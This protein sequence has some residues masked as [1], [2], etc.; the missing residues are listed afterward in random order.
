ML[1]VLVPHLPE[2]DIFPR[3]EM[4]IGAWRDRII[5]FTGIY[6]PTRPLI[7]A[8]LDCGAKAVI[9]PSAEPEESQ[10]TR[11]GSTEFNGLENGKFEIGDE[12]VEDEDTEPASP[13]SDWE[14]IETEKNGEHPMSFWD[15]EEEELSQFV[16]QLYEH[17]FKGGARVDEALQLARASHRSPRY[18]CHVP[19]SI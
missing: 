12:E 3:Y 5:I 7:K 2:T 15:D 8:L 13:S 6:G 16:C 11:L 10:L 19:G 1:L 14:D 18:S 17:L 9:C 4:Q